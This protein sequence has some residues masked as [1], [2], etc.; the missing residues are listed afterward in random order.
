METDKKKYKTII[1]D[2]FNTVALWDK[3][4][5][6][7]FTWLGEEKISTLGSLKILLEKKAPLASFDNFYRS[8]YETSLAIENDRNQ[9]SKEV[10]SQERFERVLHG[11]GMDCCKKTRTLANSLSTEHMK[12]L[13]KSCV[14]PEKHRAT[15]EA[16]SLSYRLG[17]VSNFDHAQTARSILSHGDVD[18]HFSHI[19]IS[20]EFGWRKPNHLIFE[21]AL[22]LLNSDPLN[23]LH[24]G[25]S[26][27]DDVIGAQNIKL[28]VAWVNAPN[29]EN[30]NDT[31][32]PTYEILSIVD[33]ER[34]L[35]PN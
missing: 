30:H 11:C 14:I 25:D 8:F 12:L 4:K 3:R 31:I 35:P 7:R 24:V 33:L 22:G 15:I 26:L 32:K 21:H 20:E 9:N 19:V 13:A 23:T 16:L 29:N 6:P 27:Q 5:L 10:S 28:D 2:L 18:Q 17:I 34:M 1:F